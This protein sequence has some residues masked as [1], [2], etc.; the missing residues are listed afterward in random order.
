MNLGYDD[1]GYEIYDAEKIKKKRKFVMKP[2]I[3]NFR[4]LSIL[5]IITT[6][7]LLLYDYCSNNFDID[8]EEEYKNYKESDLMFG[9]KNICQYARD[10]YIYDVLLFKSENSTISIITYVILFILF[11]IILYITGIA[12]NLVRYFVDNLLSAFSLNKIL[13]GL[14]LYKT[15]V[16]LSGCTDELFHTILRFIF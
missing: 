16:K 5:I 11:I 2:L 3:F 12:E 6:V 14:G 7:F 13:S 15:L 8:L 10:K 4:N 9:K 1:S